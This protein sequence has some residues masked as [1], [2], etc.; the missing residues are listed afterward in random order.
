MELRMDGRVALITGGSDGLG[1]AMALAFASSGADVAIV[2]RGQEKLDAAR[3]AVAESSGRRIKAYSANVS[4][5]RQISAMFEQVLADFGQVDVLVNNAGTSQTGKFEEATDEI[6]QSDIDLKLMAAVRLCRLALP[7]MKQR[8]WG[9]VIN[10]LNTAAKAPRGGS[11]PTSVTRA[12]GLALTKVLAGEGAAHNVLVNT[13]CTGIIESGQWDRHHAALSPE[14]SK[15]EFLA[16]MAK[17]RNL[18]MGRLGTSAEFANM[19]CFLASDA[20]SYIN[21][22]AI[23]VDGGLSPVV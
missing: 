15:D 21:G 9:R 22:T 12:A 14:K 13:L 3:E 8:K 4:D 6:W 17:A 7:G 19:A 16:D 23:N 1:R 5:G 11:A 2:A 18:P 20:G 10:V